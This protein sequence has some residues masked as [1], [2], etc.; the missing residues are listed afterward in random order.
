MRKRK[1]EAARELV[2]LIH[3]ENEQVKLRACI[4]ILR[5]ELEAEDVGQ[6]GW[7]TKLVE[8]SYE[9]ALQKDKRAGRRLV[10]G[11]L[12]DGLHPSASSPMFSPS[13]I[14]ASEIETLERAPPP[15]LAKAPRRIEKWR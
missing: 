4:Y 11:R 14:A 10:E 12:M 5:R 1:K 13:L 3:S 15:R 6:P 8:D 9:R 2:R 7:F